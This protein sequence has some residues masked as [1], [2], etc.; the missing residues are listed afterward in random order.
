MI[1]SLEAEIDLDLFSEILPQAVDYPDCVL[2]F[3][4]INRVKLPISLDHAIYGLGRSS[5]TESCSE[6]SKIRSGRYRTNV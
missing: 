2:D 6:V 5:R 1:W 3:I 4:H